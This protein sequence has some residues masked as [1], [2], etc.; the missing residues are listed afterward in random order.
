[1]ND[2]APRLTVAQKILLAAHR[3]ELAGHAVNSADD[4]AVEAWKVDPPTF[5][6]KGYPQYPNNNAVYATVMGKRGL[7]ALGWLD[8]TAPKQYRLSV[9]GR[10]E[11]AR[12][13]NGGGRQP[14]PRVQPTRPEEEHLSR[15]LQS[16]AVVRLRSNCGHTLNRSDATFFWQGHGPDTVDALI[17]HARDQLV[18]GHV[19][20]RSGQEVS[21]AELDELARVN[22]WL[23]LRFGP[24]LAKV[25]A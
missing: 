7:A 11:V 8:K 3:L 6:L 25:H 10:K 18:T 23:D 2:T 20:L 13:T 17:D 1:M 4:L 12:L 16:R 5:C 22:A 9:Q 24:E 14:L 15:L 21:A 19:R